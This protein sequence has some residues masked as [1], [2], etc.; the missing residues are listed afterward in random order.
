MYFFVLIGNILSSPFVSRFQHTPHI[1]AGIPLLFCQPCHIR[2][3]ISSQVLLY[4]AKIPYF[5]HT[6]LWFSGVLPCR[7]SRKAAFCQHRRY[8]CFLCR[9]W[10]FFAVYKKACRGRKIFRDML[11]VTILFIRQS[12]S[13]VFPDR[14]NWAD[15]DWWWLSH[16]PGHLQ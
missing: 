1:S 13:A 5:P 2:Q 16:L 6:S 11:S 3:Y 4:I 9:K 8:R 15:G 7:D 10:Y 12:A 14:C